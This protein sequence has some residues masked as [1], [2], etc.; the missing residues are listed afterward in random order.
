ML[1]LVHT[2][3]CG[4]MDSESLSGKEYFISFIDDKSRHTWT[5]PIKRKSDS[6]SVFLEWKSQVERSK[7]TKLKKLRSD[8]GGEY[9]SDEFE[10]YLKKEG[11]IHQRTVRKTPEQNGVA[12]RF[13]R[14]VVEAIRSMLS[15]SGLPKKFWAEALAT[16][17]YLRNRSPTKAVSG[18]TPI[19]AWSGVKPNVTHLRVFGSLCFSHI[20]KDERKKLDFKA[21]EAIFL[22]YGLETKG[23]RLYNLTTQKVFFSRDVIFDEMKF[24]NK[25]TE[26]REEVE[27][28]IELEENEYELRDESDLEEVHHEVEAEVTRRST[29]ER[30]APNYFGEWV[31]MAKEKTEEPKTVKEALNSENKVKW[32]EAMNNEIE[33][34]KKHE[35]WD[36][37][38]LPAGRKAIGSKWIFKCKTDADGNVERYKARLVAQGFTQKYG[39]DYEETF[40]PVVRFESVRTVLALAAKL[41]FKLHQM[42]IK[43][44]F[45]N[46][47][48]EE[49]IFMRQPE[50]FIEEGK[51]E[52]VCKL[53]RSIYGL[54]QQQDAGTQNLIKN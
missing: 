6:Y 22:G 51:E 19:E 31:N 25:N 53:K 9:I 45:L 30:K 24:P 21:Q 8:N 42:D 32:K 52:M 12:E 50:E 48:L 23:Y 15:E 44:A 39:I 11:I 34:L 47:E 20:P 14:T 3:V 43:T 13:N 16:A 38:K 2:D 10:S 40:S 7:D 54:K 1:E 33:S 29:R 5:Y 17:T 37:V 26:R 28:R 49:E 4:K 46:G 36:L 27:N 41:G 18:M 35:V